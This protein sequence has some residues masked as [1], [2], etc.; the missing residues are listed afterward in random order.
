MSI[1][2]PSDPNLSNEIQ[3]TKPGRIEDL[4]EH[5][6]TRKPTELLTS[7]E[8]LQRK[9]EIEEVRLAT[10]KNRLKRLYTE[11]DTL[12]DTT[13]PEAQVL[14]KEVKSVEQDILVTQ[15]V[16]D[17]LKQQVG[18]TPT[19]PKLLSTPLEIPHTRNQNNKFNPDT[20]EL[21]R[22]ALLTLEVREQRL[23]NITKQR[24]ALQ[25]DT[26]D[27][28]Y[29]ELTREI[30]DLEEIRIPEAIVNIHELDERFDQE[31]VVSAE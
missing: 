27:P 21:L 20:A 23:K 17:Q 15:S 16:I 3:K 22:S 10:R 13:T 14:L 19:E 5:V 8:S 31:A 29:L 30:K 28:Q 11:R 12:S 6:I 1:E 26:T 18:H 2:R 9:L 7:G 25:G 24:E 4:P